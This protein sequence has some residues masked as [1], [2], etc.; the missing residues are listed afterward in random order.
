[1]DESKL[2]FI[3]SLPRSG[4][5]Y[6]QNLLS[7]NTQV[8][9]CS[10]P[11]ILLNFSSLIKPDLVQGTYD[12]KLAHSAFVDFLNKFPDAQ[13]K[14]RLKNMIL[15]LYQ[16]MS[17]GY[18]FVIDKTPRYWE[19]MDEI[20]EW[21][22]K[23]K[24]IIL[25]RHPIDVATSIIKTWNVKKLSNLAR[26]QRD[27]LL[28]PKRLHEF[29]I[30]HQTNPQVYDLTYENLIDDKCKETKNLYNWLGIEYHDGILD[31]DSNTKY[32]GLYGDPFQNEL[33]NSESA[34]HRL[35]TSKLS[36]DLEEFI[37]G[38]KHYLTIQFP[39]TY[40]NYEI[41]KGSETKIFNKFQIFSND[42]DALN[43]R[44]LHIQES[45]SFKFVKI[46]LYPIFLLKTFLK[47][48]F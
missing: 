11:W 43:N 41:Q 5:T 47:R 17:S 39:T 29:S 32:K 25:K 36:R 38:Y 44:L 35:K 10:E 4:S 1:M 24:I 30:K 12:H 19:M 9:T 21:F 34:V 27:L 26:Y 28:G 23:C 3:I 8:N 40:Y 20:L 37:L 48:N 16:P 13:F 42:I 6:L 46:I 15:N 31:T 2:I 18:E 33:F 14:E 7:N 45:N 22:P